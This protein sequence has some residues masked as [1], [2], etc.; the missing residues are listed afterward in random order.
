LAIVQATLN[1]VT[2]ERLE[3][4]PEKAYRDVVSLLLDGISVERS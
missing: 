3:T 4:T 2:L 1:P